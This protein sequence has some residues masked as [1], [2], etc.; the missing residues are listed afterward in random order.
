MFSC[1]LN[2]Y[3]EGA[4]QSSSG[5]WFHN[6]GATTEK[7]HHVV[8]LGVA[9]WRSLVWVDLVVQADNMWKDDPTGDVVLNHG[10]L[11]M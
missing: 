5:S 1:L 11:Y 8:S 3:G 10:G 4:R 2:K 9:T 6:I 7:A